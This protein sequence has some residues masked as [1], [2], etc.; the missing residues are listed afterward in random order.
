MRAVKEHKGFQ[1]VYPA[2]EAHDLGLYSNRSVLG[3]NSGL[4]VR[5]SKVRQILRLYRHNNHPL[6]LDVV[7]SYPA[8]F[9]SGWLL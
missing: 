2:P 6:T 9:L 1:L 3:A 4:A 7:V 8:Y 5:F